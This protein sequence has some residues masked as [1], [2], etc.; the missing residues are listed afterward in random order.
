M[1]QTILG[2]GGAIGTELAKSLSQYTNDIRLVSRNPKKV[3]PNDELFRADLTQK[4]QVAKA[5]AGS[6]VVYVTVGFDYNTKIWQKLWLPFMKN[7]IDACLINKTKLVFFDNVYAIGGDNIKHITETSPISPTS[8]KGQVRAEVDKL[9]IEAAEKR[10]LEAIIAR[11]PD[12]FSE[13][14]D[15]S[16]LMNLVYDNLVKGRK[17]QWFCNAKVIHTT[18]YAPDLAKGTAILGNTAEAYNQIWNLPTDPEKITGEQWIKLFSDEMNATD[19]YQVL[20]AWGMK[21]LGVFVPIL[22]EMYEIRYQ[23]DRDYYFDSSKFNS[24]F[25]YIPITNRLA[26]KQ[27][28]ER[29]KQNTSS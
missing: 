4:D 1:K 29:L 26:V 5:I 17:A 9:I 7:V 8:K 20:P 25:N 18:G 11:A 16:L 19:K 28:I 15:R 24:K 6:E 23:Y 12:F 21:L 14:K 22:R 2:A 13:Y 10:S 3:N 27:T